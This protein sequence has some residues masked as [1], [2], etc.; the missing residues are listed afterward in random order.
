MENSEHKL[1]LKFPKTS[2]CCLDVEVYIDRHRINA[3]SLCNLCGDSQGTS[4]PDEFD[5]ELNVAE[6]K[7][8]DIDDI[9]FMM[10]KETFERFCESWRVYHEK[11]C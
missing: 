10:N 9:A 8:R 5:L 11:H 2:K 3:I 1:G 7:V 6:L 4:N